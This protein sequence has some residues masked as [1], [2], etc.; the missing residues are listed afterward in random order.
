M[1]KVLSGSVY[2][3]ERARMIGEWENGLLP[4]DFD[5]VREALHCSKSGKYFLHGEGGAN[6]RYGEWNGNSGSYSERIIPMS[7]SEAQIWAEKNLDGDTVQREFKIPDD[8]DDG[9]LEAIYLRITR[10][11]RILLDKERAET[12]MSISALA[13]KAIKKALGK[14]E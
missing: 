13:D 10:E 8:G 11:A 4:N 1:K 2:D 14:E 3:T 12:G 5:Y 6:S 9:E 7:A